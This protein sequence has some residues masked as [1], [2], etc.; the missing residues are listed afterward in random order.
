MVTDPVVSRPEPGEID[1]RAILHEHFGH[2]RFR[3]GQERIVRDLLAGQDVL[4]L[5]PTAAGKS[6]PYQLAALVLPGV[7]IVVS[8]LLAL[9]KD[10]V[11]ALAESGIAAELISSQL[12]ETEIAEALERVRSG[13]VRLLYVTPERFQNESFLADRA[14]LSVALFVVDEVHCISDWGHSFRPAYLALRG[15]NERVG[16]PRVV[17]R[18]MDRANLFFEVVRVDEE[19]EDRDG[20]RQLLTEAAGDYSD[21]INVELDTAMAGSGIIYCATTKATRETAEW[22]RSWGIAAD[23]YYGQRRKDDRGR[24][25]EAFMAG[26]LRVFA[27]T[28]AF[29]LGVDKPDIRFVIHRDIPA[30]LESYYQEAGRAG[31]D[32]AFAQCTI[33]YRSGDLGRAAFLAGT[34]ELT[35][36]DVHRARAGLRAAQS[37]TLRQLAER[38]DLDPADLARPLEILEEQEW[39]TQKRGRYRLTVP[40]FDPDAAPLEAEARRLAYER[41]RHEMMRAYA[42]VHVCRRRFLLN[43]FG[44]DVE[45]DDG[46]GCCD[47]DIRRDRTPHQERPDETLPFALQQQVEHDAW[48]KGV[49]HRVTADTVTVL[50]EAVGYKTLATDLVVTEGL[51]RFAPA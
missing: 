4:A 5:L 12:S 27:A 18:G 47:N 21:E 30:S 26:D 41:S 34:G 46:C 6:L 11:D 3:P 16:R 36:E 29:G 44:E 15:A 23:Y 17:A 43:Y 9:I 35:R 37:G 10:Q 42:E 2:D 22:L 48:G 45:S 24:V 7:T 33:I 31:R 8:P 19:W 20:L 38:T 51:L 28:N 50:F 25:Q 32:D 49:V 40:D 39:A 13:A 1:L 14:G